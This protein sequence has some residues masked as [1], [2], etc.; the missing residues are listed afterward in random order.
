M[1]GNHSTLRIVYASTRLLL[2]ANSFNPSP[3]EYSRKESLL[4]TSHPWEELRVSWSWPFLIYTFYF[5][6][7]ARTQSVEARSGRLL[8]DTLMREEGTVVSQ[9]V[10]HLVIT[11]GHYGSCYSS[12]RD[13]YGA[14]AEINRV[15]LATVREQPAA[16]EL[17]SGSA[18]INAPLCPLCKVITAEIEFYLATVQL[19]SSF[20]RTI[21]VFL[22]CLVRLSGSSLI[23]HCF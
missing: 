4:K 17:R 1:L 11:G 2:L 23:C 16:R 21:P 13:D 19:S 14:P 15:C 7:A 22:F 18:P 10:T 20:S 3:Q 9:F 12:W 8:F 6:R 5:R